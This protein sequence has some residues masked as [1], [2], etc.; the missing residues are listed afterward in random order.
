LIPGNSYVEA[1]E[2]GKVAQHDSTFCFQLGSLSINDFFNF[3]QRGFRTT[4]KRSLHQSQMQQSTEPN[5]TSMVRD[6]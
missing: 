1:A 3:C 6:D 4:T 5:I 2:D